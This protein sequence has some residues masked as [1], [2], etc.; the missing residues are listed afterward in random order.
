MSTTHTRGR[1]G[2]LRRDARTRGSWLRFEPLEERTLL[3]ANSLDGIKDVPQLVD[4]PSF[5]N[6]AGIGDI[7]EPGWVWVDSSN[8]IQTITGIVTES[9][10]SASDFPAAHDSHDHNTHVLVDPGQE[11]LLSIVNDPGE[12]EVEW[13]TGIRPDEQTG[14]GSTPIF[15]KWV[16][17]SDGDRVWIQ[18]NWIYDTGHPTVVDGIE[19]FRSEIHPPSAFAT[20]RDQF[21]PMPGTGGVPVHVTATDLYIHGDGGYAT[22]VLNGGLG[23]VLGGGH[24]TR[25]TPI[26]V[27]YD[28]D[29][30]LPAKPSDTAIFVSSVNDGPG[31]TIGV[32]PVLTPDLANNVVHVH[33]PLGGTGVSPLETYAR[34][35]NVGWAL[36][37]TDLHHIQ[38]SLTKIVLHDD[39]SIPGADAALTFSWLNV[40]KAGSGAWQ[41]LNDSPTND[42]SDGNALASYDDNQLLGDGELNFPDGPTFDL[43]IANGQSINVRAHAYEQDGFDGLFGLHTIA[44]VDF[45]L[46]LQIPLYAGALL[47]GGDNDGY[48]TFP[49]DG[50]LTFL[51]PLEGYNPGD[52][53]ASNPGHQFDMYFHVVD[54]PLTAAE[55]DVAPTATVNGPYTVGEGDNVVLSSAGSSDSDGSITAVQWDYNYDGVN[56]DVDATGASPTFSAAGLDGPSTR[57]IALRVIDNVGAATIATTSLTVNNVPPTASVTG[58]TFGVP[59]LPRSFTLSATDPSNAD[60]AAGFTFHVTFGDTGTQNVLPGD[61]LTISHTYTAEGTYTVTVTATDK[62]GGVSLPATQTIVIKSAGI[63]PDPTDSTKTAL[64]IGGT[65]GNDTIKVIQHGKTGN[66][67]VTINGQSKGTFSPTGRIIIFGQ[68]GNDDISVPNSVT[69]P[70]EMYGGDGNDRLSGGAGDD[71]LV[72]GLGNDDLSGGSGRDILIG[73]AG[74]DHLVGNADDDIL[75]GSTT[76]YDANF[77]A[78][79]A[80]MK[81]WSRLDLASALR[82]DH[83]KHGGGLNGLFLLDDAAIL[84]DG[85]AD[86]LAGSSG[87]DLLIQ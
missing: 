44:G 17:P 27:D 47:S 54:V 31:N 43:Y 18:G 73:G 49:D 82:I 56:F 26:D 60:T 87:D 72:G 83:L 1:S 86:I 51:D 74:T 66:Y 57:T 6:D 30:P 29:I 67:E 45:P 58:D 28:F 75:I 8:K 69:L 25:T 35:I 39:M 52:F 5:I 14:D 84:D 63:L 40:D 4:F 15:P 20:M 2:Q 65:N 32:A 16:W 42:P 64:Y 50:P 41:R 37:T 81:E 36:P 13:E 22:E 77:A 21:A 48:N 68:A 19:R 80:I 46:S 53:V 78:L 55:V 79:H 70:V 85:L 34:Q 11:N 12:M 59:G 23:L 33:V 7:P 10:V 9:A 3:A 62:D 24:D 76:I 38:V 71:L 61:P